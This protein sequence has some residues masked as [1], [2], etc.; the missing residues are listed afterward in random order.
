MFHFD[1]TLYGEKLIHPNDSDTPEGALLMKEEVQAGRKRTFS[2]IEKPDERLL[3][4]SIL[5]LEA[6]IILSVVLSVSL[7]N[8]GALYAGIYNVVF[9]IIL[10]SCFMLGLFLFLMNKPKIEGRG[11][12]MFLLFLAG[13]LTMSYGTLMY[14]LGTTENILFFLVIILGLSL[15]V[16]G[17]G[18]MVVHLKHTSRLTGYYSMWLFGTLL[19]MFMPLHELQII[20]D[21][22]G[23]DLL[24]GYL[25]LGISIIGSLSFAIEHR[26]GLNIETWVTSGDAKYIAGKFDEAIEYY[27]RALI[28]DDQSTSVEIPKGVSVHSLSWVNPY[29]EV[30]GDTVGPCV[31]KTN[32]SL[33]AS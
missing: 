6:F 5:W 12:L 29:S 17:V 25:G 10:L 7:G 20:L 9:V 30:H 32:S 15:T 4:R 14:Q 3:W 13:C 19:I 2:L 28:V 33:I 27:D 11:V 31:W 23:R 26:Q 24:V 18:L 21:Y 22:S 8:W 16:T 1:T